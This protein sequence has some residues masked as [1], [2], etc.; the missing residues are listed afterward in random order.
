MKYN[1]I[2]IILILICI[3][4]KSQHYKSDSVVVIRIWDLVEE[5]DKEYGGSSIYLRPSDKKGICDTTQ[6]WE[7]LRNGDFIELRRWWN[8]DY[9]I[10][11]SIVVEYKTEDYLDTLSD[12][13]PCINS[14]FTATA[15]DGIKYF[16]L[17]INWQYVDLD[18]NGVFDQFR[19]HWMEPN[20]YHK[21]IIY[22]GLQ[23]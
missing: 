19:F 14:I 22:C 8:K 1:F 21:R 18:R 7:V 20:A 3:P 12:G 16:S 2:L 15:S 5:E 10:R 6:K 9:G 11:Y 17:T 13:T 23:D 4:C